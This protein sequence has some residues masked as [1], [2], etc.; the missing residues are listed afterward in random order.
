MK[1]TSLRRHTR[2]RPVNPE[3]KRRRKEAGEV[4]GPYH[5]WVADES[6]APCVLRKRGG[7]MCGWWEGRTKMEAHHVATVGAGGKDAGNEVRCCPF[8]HTIIH[9]TPP[10]LLVERY[11]GVD[12]GAEAL[13]L[14]IASPFYSDSE[15]V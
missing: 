12:L 14:F 13:A 8:A 1:R 5:R 11:D 9:D 15:D 4:Y 3:R 10:S 7:H 6:D 2:V